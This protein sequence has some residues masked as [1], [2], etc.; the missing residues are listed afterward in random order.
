MELQVALQVIFA[1]C[2]HTAA[3]NTARLSLFS[4]LLSPVV[5]DVGMLTYLIQVSVCSVCG[6]PNAHSHAG[7]KLE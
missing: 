7:L 3:L 4:A 1:N 5:N 2:D 6:L